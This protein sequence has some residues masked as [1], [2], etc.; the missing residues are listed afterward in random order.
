[1]KLPSL[2]FI[3]ALLAGCTSATEN[4]ITG[5]WFMHEVIQGGRDVTSEHDPYDERF[6]ILKSDST[7]E[8]GGRPYGS[9]TGKYVY[10]T[11]DKTL[12]LDSDA[13]P[14]DDSHWKVFIRK[15]TMIWNG[16]G[17]AWAEGFQLVQVRQR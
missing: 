3:T 2:L 7:F 4:E 10:N 9:N 13:G 8:S 15:D 11:T 6:F 5:K 12:F 16:F 14:E 17:S 1:M